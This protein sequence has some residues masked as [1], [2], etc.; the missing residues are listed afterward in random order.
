VNRIL[1]GIKATY[2]FFAGD[3]IILSGTAIAFIVAAL[4]IHVNHAD[5]LFAGAFFIAIVIIS[6]VATLSRELFSHAR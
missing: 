6:L 5:N 2:N 3:A 1:Q 4:L